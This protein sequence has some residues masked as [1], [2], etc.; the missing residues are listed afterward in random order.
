VELEEGGGG[1]DMEIILSWIFG[2]SSHDPRAPLL[3]LL[4]A[5]AHAVFYIH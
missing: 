5:R 4:H 2:S 3:S 1:D